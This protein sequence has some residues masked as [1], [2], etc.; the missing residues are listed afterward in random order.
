[1]TY[2]GLGGR[3]DLDTRVERNSCAHQLRWDE[4]AT[5]HHATLRELHPVADSVI[6]VMSFTTVRYFVYFTVFG[7][8]RANHRA[9]LLCNTQIANRSVLT[10]QKSLN[11]NSN[12][13]F[14]YNN[15][16][17]TKTKTIP[18]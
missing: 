14:N 6:S 9:R 18:S 7:R 5:P 4:H 1:M 15:Y 8:N 11:Y 17:Q 3:G 16:F 2:G 13:A 10:L 12:K